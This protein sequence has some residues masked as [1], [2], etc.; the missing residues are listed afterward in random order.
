ATLPALRN[1]RKMLEIDWQNGR[2]VATSSRTGVGYVLS[3]GA[4]PA[5]P[6][7]QS[8]A[9]GAANQPTTPLLGWNAS[10]GATSYRI[11]VS[12]DPAFGSTLLDQG[13][14]T[15]TSSP[16]GTLS[17]STVYYW[18]VN[19]TNSAGTS[20]YSPT[21]TFTTGVHQQRAYWH[22][23]HIE[24]RFIGTIPPD[25][26]P[27]R[28]ITNL[29]LFDGHTF[30]KST[31]PSAPG[32][33]QPPSNILI[34]YWT[35]V[36]Q[37]AHQNGVKMELDLGTNVNS[38]Y[39]AVCA[40]GVGAMQ[41][42]AGT[43]SHY[44]IQ[45]NL[46]GADFDAE[47]GQY[48]QN[49]GMGKMAQLLHDSLAALNPGKKYDITCSMMP[50]VSDVQGYLTGTNG[51]SAASVTAACQ[52]FDQM[53]P[54]WYDQCNPLADPLYK[55]SAHGCWSSDSGVAANY[56]RAGVP[57]N[58]IGLGY[59][60]QVYDGC[61]SCITYFN[62]VIRYFPGSTVYRDDEAK[63]TWFVGNGHT[64]LYEDEWTTWWKADFI[65]RKGYGGAMGFCLG[66]GYLP[67]PPAGWDRNPAVTGLGRALFGAAPPPP[68]GDSIPPVV[69]LTAPLNG[70]SVSGIVSVTA[71]ASDNV[72]VTRVEFV[73][74]GA[75]AFTAPAAPYLYSWN[76]ASLSG[77]QTLSVKAYDAAGNTAATS[78]STVYVKPPAGAPANHRYEY[79]FPDG[80]I[81]VYDID[82]GH[83]LVKS[84]SV[85]TTTG[86]RGVAVSPNDGML[87]ISYGGDGGANGKGSLLQYDLI[88]DRVGWN[89]HY[90][91]GIDSHAISPD[92]TTIFMPD[93]EL[94]GDGKWYVVNTS[95][96]SEKGVITT[97]GYGPHNTV[98]SLDGSRVYLGDR[99][100]NN[101]GNDSL[102]VANTTTY[103]VTRKAGKFISG[104]RPFTING[105]ETFAF[106]TIT[107][108]LGFQV[109]NLTTGQVVYTVDLTT[110]G[111]SKTTCGSG[112]A[113]APSHGISLSPD[114]R[115]IYVIDQPNSYVHVFD[116]SGVSRNIAPVKLADIRLQNA[117]SGNESGCAYDCLKDGWVHHSLDGRFVYVGDAG[118][119]ISSSTRTT[120]A[121]LP[122]LKDTRKM[123]EID[124]Q[125]GHPLATSTREGLGY[126]VSRST[127]LPPTLLSPS[128]GVLHQPTTVSVSWNAAGG[129]LSYRLQVSLNSSFSTTVLDQSGITTTF[130]TTLR[131]GAGR[132]RTPRHRRPI[133]GYP[134]RGWQH[135]GSTHPG[136]PRWISPA[137]SGI[138]P[139]SHQSRL[140]RENGAD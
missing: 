120:V 88:H 82:S 62:Q 95:D 66:R 114:E 56:E 103:Q 118:D 72:G 107:G 131:H 18:H 21:W 4:P 86:T 57:H 52:Y 29:I 83:A 123:L 71:T 117:M 101:A 30:G 43:V 100:L 75:V 13:A 133:F 16:A 27:Y 50:N 10:A 73:V 44:I 65:R 128:N 3:G 47:G 25:S 23:V 49:G 8:P 2:P 87:Y 7:L 129:A 5:P 94:S 76:T 67:T 130:W 32:Y 112:C 116:V 78:R 45:F 113:S 70:D 91:H 59:A 20:L 42:W 79:V 1:T 135:R 89:V 81:Y 39:Q 139:E 80:W 125:N 54:M 115:E 90:G 19:A 77:A 58:K 15:A 37:L 55:S 40:L 96:G 17:D 60:A 119:V 134:G 14:I 31:S 48:P 63:A 64:I 126:V 122:A 111:W 46:D 53:N 74:N 33:F 98:M 110:M 108:L 28:Y 85:P 12:T 51:A 9:N 11:Q 61:S 104:I 38:E 24:N 136:L 36:L 69:S 99:D 22:T 34:P 102:Y 109:C 124:W 35:R 41:T 26:I 93:G 127:P 121:T 138:F 84:I 106:V 6:A 132:P 68:P 97:G 140:F 105:T 137:A 92:G